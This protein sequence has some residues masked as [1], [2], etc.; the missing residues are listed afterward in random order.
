MEGF[1]DGLTN[2]VNNYLIDQSIPDYGKWI[3]NR[4]DFGRDS[5]QTYTGKNYEITVE[6][7]SNVFSRIY[8]KQFNKQK[9]I[10]LE[11]VEAPMKSVTEAIQE[12]L[13]IPNV[14]A[15]NEKRRKQKY[16]DN[17]ELRR[18]TVQSMLIRGKL[19]GK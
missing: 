8:T 10:R 4:W 2:R 18:N 11:V 12:K 19:N 7:I 5:L 1:L 6:N 17:V 9:K 3:I 13:N 15:E 16:K 14:F